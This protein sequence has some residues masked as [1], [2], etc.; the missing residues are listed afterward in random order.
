MALLYPVI[1]MQPPFAH[2]DSRTNL[3]GERPSPA[4]IARWSL[5]TQ[6]RRDTPPVFIVHTSEDK[7]VPME[8]SVLFYQALRRQAC[9][10]ELHLYERGPHGF[11][12]RTDLGT[13]SGWVDRLDRVDAVERLFS[14][15]TIRT[16]R[17]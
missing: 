10:A 8:N 15:T 6:V 17:D 2:A 4:L 7:S 12:A 1:T 5:E 9:P 13:T 3:L 11:G 14:A 16:S